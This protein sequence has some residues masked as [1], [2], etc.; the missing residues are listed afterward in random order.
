MANGG[1]GLRDVK[2]GKNGQMRFSELTAKLPLT[3]EARF[4]PVQ[5]FRLAFGFV[6]SGVAAFP[7]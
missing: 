6:G 1:R 3:L 2:W 4:G 5:L 7:V